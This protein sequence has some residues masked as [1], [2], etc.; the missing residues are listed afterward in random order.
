MKRELSMFKI[1]TSKKIVLATSNTGKIKEFSELTQGMNI[2]CIPQKK[3]KVQ[4]ADE[5]GITFAENA[6]IKAR[7]ASKI[8]KMPAIADDSGLI[9]DALNGEPGIYSARYAGD[10]RDFSQNIDK[11]LAE[12]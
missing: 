7:H 8:C 12:T 2:E 9:V 11:V 1:T 4:D 3:F 5:S 10:N 6:I